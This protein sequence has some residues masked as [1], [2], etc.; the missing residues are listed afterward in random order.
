MKGLFLRLLTIMMMAATIVFVLVP[1]TLSGINAKNGVIKAT[2]DESLG[3]ETSGEPDS[4]RLNVYRIVVDSVN[5][6]NYGLGYP[7]TYKFSYPSGS[8]NLTVQ[9]CHS[10]PFCWN[11]L[12]R[13][14]SS[15]L[16]NGIEAA[17]F[18]TANSNVYISVAFSSGS[19]TTYVRLADGADD[20]VS[21]SFIEIPEYYDGRKAVVTITLDDWGRTQADE[22]SFLAAA[23]ALKDAKLWWTPGIIT[24][25][26]HDEGNME[27]TWD[28]VQ[29]VIDRG[30][31]EPG[32]HSANHYMPH[33]KGYIL[34]LEI[35][36]ARADII[37]NLD[38]PDFMKRADRE[39]L[40][41]WIQ[42]HGE[43]A[44]SI[45]KRL[46][47]LHFLADRDFSTSEHQYSWTSWV[48][49]DSLYEESYFSGLWELKS[50]EELNGYFDTA[51]D[52]GGI[53]HGA[54]HPVR[55]DWSDGGKLQN[56]IDHIKGRKDVWYVGW[57]ALYMYHFVAT[58]GIVSVAPVSEDTTRPE[59]CGDVNCDGQITPGD[60]LCA[61]WRYILG[62]FQSECE[63]EYSEM[64][65]GINCDGQITPG[66]ALC[67]VWRYILGD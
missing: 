60:A 16:F 6:V 22:G 37:D 28:S 18:D 23:A 42:P 7:I 33:E 43:T 11:E 10:F 53:Y 51:Y 24:R 54:G 58:R 57:G 63:C 44:D 30:F 41:A 67:I 29:A 12:A 32:C 52:Q 27:P 35:D 46:G 20:P 61:F 17:R 38:L 3:S 50:E 64:T 65:A 34:N 59:L 55:L 8:S 25:G 9:Y 21:M 39:Y 36:S 14:N 40:W 45:R 62:H 15:D 48:A 19:D 31:V 13:K 26:F 49:A 1:H 2:C 66:D 5:H 56:H 4:S 47:H